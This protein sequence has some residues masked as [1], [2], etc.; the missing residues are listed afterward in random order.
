MTFLFCY[1]YTWRQQ[2]ILASAVRRL[3]D[4]SEKGALWPA[5]GFPVDWC[6]SFMYKW[7]SALK[8]WIGEWVGHQHVVSY[9]KLDF[10]CSFCYWGLTLDLNEHLYFKKETFKWKGM[11]VSLHYG[12]N[13]GPV[14][15]VK[16]ACLWYLKEWWF[17]LC[18]NISY[19]LSPVLP[20]KVVQHV[21]MHLHTHVYTY[22][23]TLKKKFLYHGSGGSLS[24]SSYLNTFTPNIISVNPIKIVLWLSTFIS[25][26]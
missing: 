25:L 21:H 3:T 15:M 23:H 10:L 8:S 14:N 2:S 13:S 26:I 5:C 6:N 9:S 19:T 24:L 4:P 7:D 22:T 16:C 1:C 11:S 18:I 17:Y 20:L 12:D